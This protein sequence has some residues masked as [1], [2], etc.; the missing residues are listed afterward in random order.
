M[1]QG[2]HTFL[3]SLKTLTGNLFRGR[4]HFSKGYLG[5]ILTLEDGREYTVFRHLMVDSKKDLEETMVVFKVR[6]KFS[7]F[8]VSI[9]KRLSM[10]PTPFLIANPGFRQK[11][12]IISNDGY[13]QGIYQWATKES[14]EKYP[15]SFIFKMMTKRSVSDTMSYEIIH[16]T[17]LSDYIERLIH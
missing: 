6:F 1:K 13:F 11:I 10:F 2:N 5:K 16:D 9:N 14:A 15:E 17:H 7:N 3:H 4:V 12:W 8:P